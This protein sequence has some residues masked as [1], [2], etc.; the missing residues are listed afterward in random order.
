MTAEIKPLAGLERTVLS[1]VIPLETPYS[2]FIFPTTY[3]NF[4]CKYC[5]HSLGTQKMKEQYN[6]VHENMSMETFE[7]IIFQLK[8]FPNKIRQISLTGQGEPLLNPNI[9][10]MVK[11][12]K[13]A[14]IT[15]R[16]EIISNGSLLSHSLADDLV[17]NG[18]D[19]LRISIQGIKDEK[20]KNICGV[21]YT[22]NE[23]VD[24]LI[25]FSKVKKDTELFVKIMDIAL[26]SNEEHDFFY[27]TF[28][29]I[30]DRMFIEHCRPVYDGVPFTSNLKNT[31][32]RYGR[33]HSHR[34]VCPLPFFMLGI[35]PSGDVVPC[36]AIYKPVVL[37][38]V[39]KEV[40]L[41]MWSGDKLKE[42]QILQLEKK[43]SLHSK[44]KVCCA[45]DDVSHPEDVLDNNT[46]EIIERLN[47]IKH[48]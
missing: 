11:M 44:C 25:Y 42:F 1:K 37:G 6:F 31:K 14:D 40:L 41:D 13:S 20:Y 32:D 10:T 28:S 22:F 19:C 36:D 34:E 21:D 47:S 27:N 9:V 12:L 5:A 24:N 16:I 15:D 7:K 3:C 45:P 2:V 38:N 33:L 35:F 43:R 39:H 8:Q 46:E 29:N 4:K 23:I 18:L 26:D 48:N 30:A 17:K